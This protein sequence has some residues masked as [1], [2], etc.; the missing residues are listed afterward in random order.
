MKEIV[1]RLF[2][3]HPRAAGEGYVQHLRFAWH[4]AGVMAAGTTVALLHGVLPCIL[5]TAAGDRIRALHALL[6]ARPGGR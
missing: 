6:D 3:A 1:D 5:Q 2:L 4:V